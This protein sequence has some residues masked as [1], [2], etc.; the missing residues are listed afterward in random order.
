MNVHIN[1]DSVE[2]AQHEK[3][4]KLKEAVGKIFGERFIAGEHWAQHGGWRIIYDSA[5]AATNCWCS[6]PIMNVF[7]L[8][9][10][11]V[12]DTAA[13]IGKVCMASFDNKEVVEAALDEFQRAEKIKRDEET[14]KKRKREGVVCRRCKEVLMNLRLKVQREDACCSLVCLCTLNGDLCT[15]TDCQGPL[16]REKWGKDK[17]FCSDACYSDC[18]EK[19]CAACGEK[20]VAAE[21]W[22]TKCLRCYKNRAEDKV[23]GEKGT[24]CL[25]G[26]TNLFDKDQPWKIMCV[27]C[28]VED[29]PCCGTSK[30]RKVAKTGKVYSR[31]ATCGAFTWFAMKK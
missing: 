23:A 3:R 4:A 22:K 28:A 6:T 7:L 8:V 18:Y 31:C 27:S 9:N 17:Q 5:H 21:K 2:Y 29:L 10:E 26:C 1:P 19:A 14:R 13:A 11:N 15:Y 25:E 30:R 16:P 24:C 20:F 12:P